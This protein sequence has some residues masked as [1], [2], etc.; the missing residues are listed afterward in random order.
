MYVL[1]GIA[2]P[3]RS[4]TVAR[5]RKK[6]RHLIGTENVQHPRQNRNI[7]PLKRSTGSAV[8]VCERSILTSGPDL[9]CSHSVCGSFVE[10]LDVKSP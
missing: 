7:V 8:T 4:A 2:N 9:A 10:T 6:V 5:L 1:A 3:N